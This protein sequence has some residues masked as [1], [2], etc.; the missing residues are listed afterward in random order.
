MITL[1]LFARAR[2]L[3][4]ADFLTW[5]LSIP[6]TCQAFRDQVVTH[7]PALAPLADHL[8]IAV[9]GEFQSRDFL[10][11]RPCEVALFPP[12]SGG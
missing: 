8:L 3:V 5:T 11:A 10:L 4:G 12:V 7:Y 1:R 6:T 2:D 9:D